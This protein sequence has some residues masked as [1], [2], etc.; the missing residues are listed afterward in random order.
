MVPST[1]P[2]C[3]SLT[4]PVVLNK[5]CQEFQFFSPWVVLNILILPPEISSQLR[6]PS[7]VGIIPPTLELVE[8]MQNAGKQMQKCL[9]VSTESYMGQKWFRHPDQIRIELFWPCME[10][11]CFID[12]TILLYMASTCKCLRA[13]DSS[14]IML[15][16]KMTGVLSC[17]PSPFHIIS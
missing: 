11:G 1:C 8:T 2:T 5:S 3:L 13:S 7:H 14:H 12:C 9:K 17:V 15:P 6:V 16:D 10:K 4:L